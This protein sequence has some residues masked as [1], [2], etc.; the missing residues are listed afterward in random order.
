[1]RHTFDAEL[2]QPCHDPLPTFE[3]SAVSERRNG[4]ESALT[5]AGSAY[6]PP[7][8]AFATDVE[9]AD[10]VVWWA[11]VVGLAYA[12]ALA[13]AAWCRSRGGNAEI[14]FGWKGFKVVCKSP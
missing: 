9:E 2:A 6:E 10:D 14:S 8:I 4:M 13:W 11:V 3:T 12:I 1:V 5:L 7:A